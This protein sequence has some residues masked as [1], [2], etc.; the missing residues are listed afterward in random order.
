MMTE[1]E[2][3]EGVLQR[4]ERDTMNTD[5][6]RV[7]QGDD[8]A[9]ERLDY[10]AT[11][12]N[13]N[14]QYWA[15]SNHNV[16]VATLAKLAKNESVWVRYGVCASPNVTEEIH[17]ELI[18]DERWDIRATVASNRTTTSRIL[19]I[20]ANDNVTNVRYQVASNPSTSVN[21]LIKL[22]ED[23]EPQ[24]REIVIRRS[25]MPEAVKLW[26]KMGGYAGMTLAE[27]IW[28]VGHE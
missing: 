18:R 22:A 15:A 25:D 1:A 6:V 12:G 20:L 23:P 10:L 16:S 4:V 28:Q 21:T 9:P 3:K 24:I 27:F 17:E 7:A 19:D 8:V 11:Y 14:A 2:Y 13:E 5:M 26:V